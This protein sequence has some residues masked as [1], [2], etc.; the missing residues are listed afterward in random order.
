MKINTKYSL[1]D[2]IY[3]M[4]NNKVLVTHIKS[5]AINITLD[6]KGNLITE[7]RYETNNSWWLNENALFSSKEELLESL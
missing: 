2:E 3:A 7:T 1:G 5:I 6:Y 4:G